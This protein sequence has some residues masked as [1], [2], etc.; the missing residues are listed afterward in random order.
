LGLP[1]FRLLRS[2][3]VSLS[4]VSTPLPRG[5]IPRGSARPRWLWES[6]RWFMLLGA[7]K[8]LPITDKSLEC[9]F[10]R[11]PTACPDI[12][13]RARMKDVHGPNTTLCDM[14]RITAP[15]MQERRGM[16]LANNKSVLCPPNCGTG[17]ELWK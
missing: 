6:V 12:P 1:G 2:C 8:F 3:P 5:T 13:G 10:A 7:P 4:T 14:M 15:T 9:S 11:R 17:E 16:Q